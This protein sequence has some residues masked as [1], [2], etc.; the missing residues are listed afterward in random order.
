MASIGHVAVGMAAARAYSG[1]ERAS[2]GSMAAWSALSMLPDADV[3]AFAFGIAYEDPWG[4]RGASHSLLVAAALGSVAAAAAPDLRLPRIRTWLLATTVLASHGL[5]DTLTDGGLGCAL[6]W[7]FDLTRYFAPWRPIPVS[8]IGLG[9]LSPYGAVVAATELILFAPL[10]FMALRRRR[11]L[12]PRATRLAM[13]G[14]WTL[15]VWLIGSTDPVRQALF[16]VILREDTEYAQGYSE[17]GFASISAGMAA[18]DVRRLVGPPFEQWWHYMTESPDDCRLIRLA[19]DT[20][21]QWRNFGRC[22][23]ATVQAGMSSADVLRA[24]GPPTEEIWQYSRSR[25]GGWF[26]ARNVFFFRGNVEEILRR[27]SP[28][29]PE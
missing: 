16:G 1:E 4:H 20:V 18:A 22:T 25:G 11:R 29:Q 13:L 7:P 21:T 23:P 26:Q 8:P 17:R 28:N 2:L 14:A 10:L 24:L 6:L 5:L 19:S 9:F 12:R 27:W 3:I 15:F